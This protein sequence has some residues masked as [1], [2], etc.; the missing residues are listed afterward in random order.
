MFLS[1]L[2]GGRQMRRRISWYG[3]PLDEMDEDNLL[4]GSTTACIAD[5]CRYRQTLKV[6]Y[7][8]SS[9]GVTVEIE[10]SGA[11][12][13]MDAPSGYGST[14][15]MVDYSWSSHGSVKPAELV[16]AIRWAI[17]QE[18]DIISRYGKP[19]KNFRWIVDGRR[20]PGLNSR[21]AVEALNYGREIM[22]SKLASTRSASRRRRHQASPGS[23]QSHS[24]M[25]LDLRNTVLTALGTWFSGG[26]EYINPQDAQMLI[27][28][29]RKFPAFEEALTD[30][31]EDVGDYW[32]EYED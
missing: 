12:G 32:G 27:R 19:T 16:D 31:M 22:N 23:M 15:A 21:N 8:P 3:K 24:R 7:H 30:L 9:D 28:K 29:S 14:P 2:G 26:G 25:M 6:Y 20:I 11:A 4:I 13:G 10:G 18:G 5:D 17:R 1:E